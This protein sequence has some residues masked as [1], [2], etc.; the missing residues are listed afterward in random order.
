[1]TEPALSSPAARPPIWDALVSPLRAVEVRAWLVPAGN[2]AQALSDRGPQGESMLHWAALS[3]MGLVLDLLAIGL[4]PNPVDQRGRT[5]VDWQFERLWATHE[6]GIGNLTALNLRKLRLQS[7]DLVATLWRQGGRPASC[8]VDVRPL[9]MRCGLWQTLHAWRDLDPNAWDDWE[10]SSALHAWPAA[11][12]EKG[13]QDFL[14][15]WRREGRPIDG[16]DKDGRTPL[17]W[18]VEERLRSDG[19]ARLAAQAAVQDL[20]G[21][22]ADPSIEDRE[23]VSPMALPLLRGADDVTLAFLTALMENGTPPAG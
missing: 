1:M 18:A 3:D 12:A 5:P 6:A 4:E 2:R 22:G 9:A 23:G 10:S 7:D 15:I 11:P 20:I 17:W 14:E 16:L 19:K 21:A 13:R 8:P